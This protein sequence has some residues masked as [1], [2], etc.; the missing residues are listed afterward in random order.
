MVLIKILQKKRR[1]TCIEA[2]DMNPDT[3]CKMIESLRTP[4]WKRLEKFEQEREN[5]KRSKFSYIFL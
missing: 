3:I 5:R 4:I 2:L 1:Y